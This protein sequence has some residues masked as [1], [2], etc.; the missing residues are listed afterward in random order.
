MMTD[1]D[2]LANRIR[3][4]TPTELLPDDDLD[5]LFLLY[6]LLGSSK[7]LEVTAR[8]VH[9]A[10]RVWILLRGQRDHKSLVPFEQLTE[11]IQQADVPFME[12]IHIAV[13][14]EL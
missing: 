6:A 12:A 4:A 14:P 9:D 5:S 10:W 8:D 7:G 2:D 3:S 1:L 13:P 11:E